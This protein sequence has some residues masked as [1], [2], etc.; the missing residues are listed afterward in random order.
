M[1]ENEAYDYSEEVGERIAEWIEENF[2][3]ENGLKREPKEEDFD[4]FGHEFVGWMFTQRG[5][6]LFSSYVSKA[7][8]LV[9]RKTGYCMDVEMHTGV[10]YP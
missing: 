9:E 3:I 8:N 2:T 4:M 5:Q 6:R 10:I 7:N 1:T